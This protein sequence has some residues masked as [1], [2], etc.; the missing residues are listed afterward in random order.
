MHVYFGDYTGGRYLKNGRGY[1]HSFTWIPYLVS[2]ELFFERVRREAPAFI[3]K[4]IVARS[5]YMLY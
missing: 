5:A 4:V 1:G 2:R 3:P